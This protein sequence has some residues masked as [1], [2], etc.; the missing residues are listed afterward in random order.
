MADNQ[1]R[2]H[3]IDGA[4]IPPRSLSPALHRRYRLGLYVVA[5]SL[6]GCQLALM[7]RYMLTRTKA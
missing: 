7:A 2:L 1:R 6:F 5:N 4:C 3:A